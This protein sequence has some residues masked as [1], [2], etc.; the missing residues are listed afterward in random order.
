MPVPTHIRGG[1]I[2]YT[3]IFGRFIGRIAGPVGWSI[4]AYDISITLYRT[5]V[6]Y[7]RIINQHEI[8]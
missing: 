7:N 1:T 3:K 4:L 6:I 5:Q 8:N 2:R